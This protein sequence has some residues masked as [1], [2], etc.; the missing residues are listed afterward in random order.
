MHAACDAWFMNL[1][2]YCISGTLIVEQLVA[3]SNS[4]FSIAC[5]ETVLWVH[6]FA[7]AVAR[8]FSL[9]GT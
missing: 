6:V 9:K 4:A 7:K 8:H 5:I 2:A 3:A 1:T